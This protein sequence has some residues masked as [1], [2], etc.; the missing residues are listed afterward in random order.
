MDSYILMSQ[1]DQ[2]ESVT[3]AI[4][5]TSIKSMYLMSIQNTIL[6]PAPLAATIK[7]QVQVTCDIKQSLINQDG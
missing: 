6:M 4:I 2:V 1:R 7:Y 5:A 3:A